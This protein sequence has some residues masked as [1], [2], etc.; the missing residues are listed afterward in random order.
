MYYGMSG[1]GAEAVTTR[2]KRP[3]R[4][5]NN[6]YDNALAHMDARANAIRSWAAQ[7]V[8]MAEQLYTTLGYRSQVVSARAQ[9][10]V[11]SQID[12][13]FATVLGGA[14]DK[15][16][17]SYTSNFIYTTLQNIK[18]DAPEVYQQ[19]QVLLKCWDTMYKEMLS[20]I[21]SMQTS[22]NGT[23]GGSLGNTKAAVNGLLSGCKSIKTNYERC[24]ANI[25]PV[26]RNTVASAAIRWEQR[27]ADALVAQERAAAEAVQAEAAR[28]AAQQAADAAAAQQAAAVQQAAETEAAA[29]EAEVQDMEKVE[30]ATEAGESAEGF[31]W[32]YVAVGV[33]LVAVV[34]GVAAYF[35]M[36]K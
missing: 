28:I 9:P 17:Q 14:L 26:Y 16:I 19:G 3:S 7:A 5:Q 31:P 36:K 25:D 24:A 27:K 11:V 18:P 1:L 2:P 4:P 34:G 15:E 20:H 13:Y 8:Q 23:L 21:R 6:P 33:G 22:I 35:A 29:A 12:N 30:A 32:G 10:G